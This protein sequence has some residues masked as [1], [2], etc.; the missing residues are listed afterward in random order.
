[1]I[2][3]EGMNEIQIIEMMS[4]MNGSLMGVLKIQDK[5]YSLFLIKEY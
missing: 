1:M 2:H 3:D 4:F 5:L